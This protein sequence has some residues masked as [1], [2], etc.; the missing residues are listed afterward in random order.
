MGKN[1]RKETGLFIRDES[2]KPRIKLYVDAQGE[3]RIEMLNAAGEK[4]PLR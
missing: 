1:N 2:G 4:L 3:A